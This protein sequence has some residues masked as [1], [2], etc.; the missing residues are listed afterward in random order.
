[1]SRYSAGYHSALFKLGAHK[2]LGLISP[3]FHPCPTR[4]DKKSPYR[5][6]RKWNVESATTYLRPSSFS[7]PRRSVYRGEALQSAL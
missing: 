2:R 5:R 7:Q 4:N 3:T 6:G 1:M